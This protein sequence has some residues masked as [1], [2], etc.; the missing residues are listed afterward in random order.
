MAWAGPPRRPARRGPGAA[1]RRTPRRSAA[2]PARRRARAG[3]GARRRSSAATGAAAAPALGR[4]RPAPAPSAVAAGRRRGRRPAPSAAG[5]GPRPLRRRRP[6][7]TPHARARR[8]VGERRMRDRAHP[9][10]ADTS[11][12]HGPS[13]VV[14]PLDDVARGAGDRLPVQRHLAAARLGVEAAGAPARKLDAGLGIAVVADPR[15]PVGAGASRVSVTTLVPRRRLLADRCQFAFRSAGAGAE[16]LD[17]H[18]RTERLLE[19]RRQRSAAQQVVR[20]ARSPIAAIT[21][22][23]SSAR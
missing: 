14:G 16:L 23:W 1:P 11:G 6:C 21:I 13:G 9:R 4:R 2:R 12:S 19:R 3:R 22:P 20:S 17:R 7:T 8:C 15:L 18:Q 5:R 10:L